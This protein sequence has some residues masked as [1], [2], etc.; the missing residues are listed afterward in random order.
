MLALIERTFAAFGVPVTTGE[1]RVG[2]V[3]ETIDLHVGAG[4][5]IG[6]V[7]ALAPEVALALHVPAVRIAPCPARGC[8]TIEVPLSARRDVP[9]S[10]PAGQRGTLPLYLGEAVDGA[11]AWLDLVTAPHL[12]VAGTT[13]SGK[14]V[15]LTSYIAALAWAFS[16]L[17][18]QLV[19]ID[20][21][22]TEFTRWRNL[23]H[24]A[25][26]G[27]ATTPGRAIAALSAVI[28]QMDR[29]YTEL[30][31]LGSQQWQGQR[32]VIVIDELADL[33]MTSKR[34]VEAALCRI[35]QLGRA[36]G[37]HLICATQRPSVDVITGLIKANF[38]TRLSFRLRTGTDSRTILDASGAETLL[39]R[40]DSLI[41]SSHGLQRV[42]GA[43]PTDAEIAD[44]VAL[45]A[46]RAP[47][48]PPPPPVPTRR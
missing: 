45:R 24:L 11:P 5:R 39:G 16:G 21:K 18:V 2:A 31:A 10:W 35:A 47:S 46:R 34:G 42:H 23:E 4:M 40:G 48:M 15:A 33:M 38:P 12:L 1:R 41:T 19:L 17:D 30:A 27:I 26:H 32:I 44:I 43:C 22:Q 14:S 25:G 20:P 28:D 13:G 6:R 36:A 7:I 9:M 8:L 29:R 3:V 37:I